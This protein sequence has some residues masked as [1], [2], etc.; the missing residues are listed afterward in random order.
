MLL[1]EKASAKITLPVSNAYLF[2]N[3]GENW[4]SLLLDEWDGDVTGFQMWNFG[5]KNSS[6]RYW[7]VELTESVSASSEDAGN[8]FWRPSKEGQMKSMWDGMKIVPVSD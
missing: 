4:Q 2:Y 5:M 8:Y 6:M 7:N 3:D 1:L